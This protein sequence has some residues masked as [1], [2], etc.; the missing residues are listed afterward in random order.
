MH[1][2]YFN[3][4][5]KVRFILMKIR[6]SD[7]SISILAILKKH[8]FEYKESNWILSKWWNILYQNSTLQI[9]IGTDLLIKMKIF[10]IYFFHV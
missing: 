4:L 2:S 9:I 5:T 3:A 7:K 10:N 1:I 8:Q 6:K